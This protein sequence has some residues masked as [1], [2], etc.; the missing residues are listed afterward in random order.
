VTYSSFAL[1]VGSDPA[2]CGPSD[3]SWPQLPV[4]EDFETSYFETLSASIASNSRAELGKDLPQGRT[5]IIGN[6]TEGALLIFLR[7]LGVDYRAQRAALDVVKTFPFSSA[8]KRMSTLVRSSGDSNSEGYL[9]TKG[10][11]EIITDMCTSYL[12]HD[13]SRQ[14][15]DPQMRAEM[16]S[17]ITAMAGAGLRTI[18]IAFCPVPSLELANALEEAPGPDMAMI[19]IALVGIRDP[20]RKAAVAPPPPLPESFFSNLLVC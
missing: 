10:A 11:S 4:K 18:A 5:E 16:M 2:V 12:A 3:R 20:P 19:F 8:Q 1:D 14:V 6:K 15:I 9:Y 17:Q 7:R 13:G